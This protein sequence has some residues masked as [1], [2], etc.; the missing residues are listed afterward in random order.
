MIDA[1]DLFRAF[2]PHREKAIVTTTGRA[3]RHWKDISNDE[4]RDITLGGAM[5]HTASAAFGLAT[6]P[7]ALTYSPRDPLHKVVRCREH[8]QGYSNSE[9]S[10]CGAKLAS[11][12][13]ALAYFKDIVPLVVSPEGPLTLGDRP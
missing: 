2:E 6:S 9:A 7:L 11:V 5:G 1:A 10:S 13:L 12:L 8:G 4:K 3:G